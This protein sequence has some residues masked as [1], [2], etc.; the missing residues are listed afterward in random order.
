[1][2]VCDIFLFFE[3]WVEGYCCFLLSDLFVDEAAGCDGLH[4]EGELT[5]YL[6]ILF[7]SQCVNLFIYMIIN[8]SVNISPTG[9]MF[10]CWS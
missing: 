6:L 2:S 3:D 9:I 10:G 4:C 5:D 8:S 7:L 1:M